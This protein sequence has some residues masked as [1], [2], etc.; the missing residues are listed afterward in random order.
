M[1]LAA[2]QWIKMG[3]KVGDLKATELKAKNLAGVDVLVGKDGS[4]SS[5]V[6]RTCARTSACS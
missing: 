4:G 6:W 3:L 1:I 5:S 2:L